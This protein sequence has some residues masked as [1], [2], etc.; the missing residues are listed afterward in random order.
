MSKVPFI[1]IPSQCWK[2]R[3]G[4]ED[5]EG[6]GVCTQ[7]FEV[8]ANTAQV[9]LLLNGKSLGVKDVNEHCAT[10]NVPFVNGSNLLVLRTPDGTAQDDFLKVDFT[11]QPFKL[12]SGKFSEIAVNCGSQ[13][14]VNDASCADYLWYPDSS[15]IPGYFGH[16]GGHYFSRT[17]RKILSSDQNI[18]GTSLD[19]VYQTQLIGLDG[20]RFDVRDGQYEV[21]LLFAD[22]D[23]KTAN[24]FDV[25]L[26]GD[27]VLRNFDVK[28]RFGSFNAVRI[29]YIV[30]AT[31]N[32]G[33][34]IDF[35]PVK[36]STFVNGIVVRQ[37]Y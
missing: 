16:V 27:K 34:R 13:S 23:P 6:A 30:N 4:R 2:V 9:E 1:S 5:S 33:I 36:G 26:N 12:N 21:S 7:P 14:Y 8:F 19:P 3:G 17:S 10:F 11:V 28:S 20:Y 32:S 29:R 37:V 24:V 35:T 31:H 22:L 25:S 15:Y 18:N